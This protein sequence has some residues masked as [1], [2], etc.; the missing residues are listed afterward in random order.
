MGGNNTSTSDRVAAVANRLR[1]AQVDFAD[2]DQEVRRDYLS[3]EVARALADIVPGERARFLEELQ[4]R[5]PTW[6]AT[7]ASHRGEPQEQFSKK[8]L[9]DPAYLLTR[10]IQACKSL[11][12]NSK[13]AVVSK[14][15]QETGIAVDQNSMQWPTEPLA[16]LRKKLQMNAQESVD[17]RRA[18]HLIGMLTEFLISIESAVWTAWRSVAAP[19]TPVKRPMNTQKDIR[20]FLAGDEE[21]SLGQVAQDIGKDRALIAALVTAIP[22]AGRFATQY[23]NACSP[24]EIKL[25]VGG[26]VFG[27]E[28]KFWRKYV[29]LASARDTATVNDEIQRAIATFVEELIRR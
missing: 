22:Q 14:F 28:V 10:L 11:P 24:E 19:N 4:S 9:N 18:L 13:R 1:L 21:M 12:D 17:P 27:A 23:I 7:A 8:E 6:D 20:R 29:E 5:F 3:E 15:Q 16:E 2:E 25:L 26:S